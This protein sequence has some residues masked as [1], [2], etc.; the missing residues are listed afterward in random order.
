MATAETTIPEADTE[1]D[2]PTPMTET[3][4]L[5]PQMDYDLNE[6]QNMTRDAANRRFQ[7]ARAASKGNASQLAQ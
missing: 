1:I 2:A 6:I 5:L 3:L 7:E 4:N